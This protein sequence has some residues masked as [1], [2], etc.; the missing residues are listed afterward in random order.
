MNS[1]EKTL[2]TFSTRVRQMILHYSKMKKENNDLYEMVDERD[3]RIKQLEARL[4]QAENDYNSLKMA[5]MIEI[6][7]ADMNG[8][9]KRLAKLIRDVN[10]CIT[11]LSE[12]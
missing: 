11:L 1:N 10:K 8:A 9:K 7:D 5:K 4:T 12:K 2:T 3:S 6:S